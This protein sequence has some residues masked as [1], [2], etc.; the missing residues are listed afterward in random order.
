MRNRFLG[1]LSREI[2]IEYK[3]CLYFCCM[4]FFYFGYLLCTGR[5]SA[6]ILMMW[7]MILTAYFVGDLQVYF[8]GNFDESERLGRRENAA[9]CLCSGIYIAASLFF[10]WFEGNIIAT[11]L[12]FGY[13]LLCYVCVYLCNKVKRKIDTDKLNA[14]LTAYKESREYESGK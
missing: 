13:L 1:C 5:D 12:F 2:A 4:L 11:V 9:I 14:M 7:E 8:L 10:G 3:A 6:S